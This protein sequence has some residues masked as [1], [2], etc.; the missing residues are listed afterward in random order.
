[1]RGLVGLAHERSAGKKK[2]IGRC[3]AAG[4]ER[5]GGESGPRERKRS[6]PFGQIER[7]EDF[8]SFKSFSILFSKPNSNVNQIKFE[9]GLKY[10]FQFK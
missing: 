3:W 10:T 4:R 9:Y 2:D 8:P 7:R 5:E 1:M 6:R